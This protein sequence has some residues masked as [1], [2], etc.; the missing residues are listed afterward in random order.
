MHN[1]TVK[2]PAFRGVWRV[3]AKPGAGGACSCQLDLVRMDASIPVQRG[4]SEA[5]SVGA[6]VEVGT[7]A[8]LPN[9]GSHISPEH[10]RALGAALG[11]IQRGKR[12]LVENVRMAGGAR[13]LGLAVRDSIDCC[14]IKPDAISSAVPIA[15]I[16]S[17]CGLSG[18][19]S[20]AGV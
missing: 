14:M 12:V 13:V 3:W 11:R 7:P 18:G 6:L 16:A 9:N 8:D 1:A 17:A 19:S 10:C 2:R 20:L 4:D 5:R 15:R